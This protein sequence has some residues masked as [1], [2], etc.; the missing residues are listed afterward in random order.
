MA[1]SAPHRRSPIRA[2]R[3]RLK[4]DGFSGHLFAFRSKRARIIKI[5]FW[6]GAAWAIIAQVRPGLFVSGKARY[7]RKCDGLG[8]DMFARHALFVEPT[9]FLKLSERSRLTAAW[10]LQVSGRSAA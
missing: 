7:L 3:A 2:A 5:L 6:L 4:K 10:S 9:V 8:L 1:R